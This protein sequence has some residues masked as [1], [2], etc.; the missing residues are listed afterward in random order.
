MRIPTG[1]VSPA[2]AAALW[3]LTRALTGAAADGSAGPADPRLSALALTVGAVAV[4]AG[5]G[6][7]D[8]ALDRTAALA[9]FPR[10]VAHLV[11]G[12]ASAG[13]A[14]LAVHALSGQEPSVGLVARDT[15]GLMGLVGIG[16]ACCGQRY[17]WLPAF[18]WPAAAFVV[19]PAPNAATRILTWM[20]SAPDT[21]VA[22]WTAG[23]LGACGLLAYGIAG[24][25]R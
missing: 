11:L 7:Q 9:W 22:A 15:A 2:G 6:G 14:L 4:S 3:A 5:L 25:R 16:A 19:P 24:P 10:R 8:L 20:L 12:G 1:S 13:A 17:A 18:T 23:A 21:T